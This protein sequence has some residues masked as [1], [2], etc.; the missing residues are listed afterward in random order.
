MLFTPAQERA[1]G[2]L[3]DCL[4]PPDDYPGAWE[5]GA[6]EYIT[7]LLNTDCAHLQTTYRLG[8][9]SLDAEAVALYGESFGDA[10]DEQRTLLLTRV[11]QGEVVANWLVSPQS[12]FSMWVN[13]VAESYYSDSGNG[14]NRG[15]LSWEM[16][17]FEAQ[18]GRK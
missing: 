9:D 6:G 7:R 16:I 18:G 11:E 10:T 1:L 15:N 3:C 13:H 8:L 12:T 4:I 17:G 5:A 14:G 2:F